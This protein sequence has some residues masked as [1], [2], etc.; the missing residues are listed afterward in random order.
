MSRRSRSPRI[1]IAEP[2][3]DQDRARP[4][5]KKNAEVEPSSG[6]G[7]GVT[8]WKGCFVIKK[9]YQSIVTK[10]MG[11]KIR[12]KKCPIEVGESEGRQT[13]QRKYGHKLSI[14]TISTREP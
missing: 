10:Y 12:N 5:T 3:L 13:E 6:Q 8:K 11:H 1:S 14:E 2:E 4:P 7:E 9:D